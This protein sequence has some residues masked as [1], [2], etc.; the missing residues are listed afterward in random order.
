MA[1]EYANSGA[2][3]EHDIDLLYGEHGVACTHAEATR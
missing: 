1:W 3:L 2:A